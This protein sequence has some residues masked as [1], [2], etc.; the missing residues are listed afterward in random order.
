MN[1]KLLNKIVQLLEDNKA[2][3]IV[4]I[5]L[6][7]KSSIADFMIVASGTSSKHIQSVS[8]ILLQNLKNNGYNNCKIEGS[9]SE[10]WKLID[11]IDVIVNLFHPEKRYIY[12]LEKMWEDILPKEQVRI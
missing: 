7:D 9:E 10:D 4:T 8:E 3:N 12:N 5:N 1:K 6:K 11:A 2:S